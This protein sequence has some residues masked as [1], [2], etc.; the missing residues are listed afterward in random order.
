M[1]KASLR[2]IH[3]ILGILGEDSSLLLQQS[4]LQYESSTLLSITGTELRD[5]IGVI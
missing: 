4:Q 1:S 5:T 2:G 3:S